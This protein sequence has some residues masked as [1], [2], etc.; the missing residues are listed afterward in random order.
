MRNNQFPTATA[1][2]LTWTLLF[3]TLAFGQ[4]PV[5][6]H[7]KQSNGI[8]GV[9]PSSGFLLEVAGAIGNDPFEKD[10]AQVARLLSAKS[11]KSVVLIDEYGTARESF[12]QSVATRLESSG[13]GKRIFRI[14]WNAIFSLAK[15]DAAVDRM[16]SGILSEAESSKGKIAIYLEDIAGFSQDTPVL[17]TMVAKRLYDALSKG[18]VQ[19]LSATDI[20]GFDRQIAADKKLRPRFERIVLSKKSDE[21]SF[22]G[23]K[24]SPDLRELVAGADQTGTAKVILQS[25]DTEIPQIL[26]ALKRNKVTIEARADGLNMLVID[27]P[28]SAAEEIARVKSAKHLSLDREVSALGHIETTTGVSLVRSMTNTIIVGGLLNSV[29]GQLDGSG[30]GVAVLDSGI[31]QEHNS[32]TNS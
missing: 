16:L 7:T 8:V 31:Y 19:I 15:D 12:L 2:V 18:S 22:V 23:D 29:S 28:V 5:R 1:Y 3:S 9:L 13:N 14:N 20:G 30:I 27:L 11:A 32:F 21:D 24:L 4:A 10:S 25:D 17:G 6:V 26:D